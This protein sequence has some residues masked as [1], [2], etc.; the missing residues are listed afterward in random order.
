[1]GYRRGFKDMLPLDHDL[2]V[3]VSMLCFAAQEK[4]RDAYTAVYVDETG[5]RRTYHGGDTYIVRIYMDEGFYVNFKDN[6]YLWTFEE[7]YKY[8]EETKLDFL[9]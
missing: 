6:E 8:I 5:D 1:M 9:E 4:T 2:M 7:L 3:T